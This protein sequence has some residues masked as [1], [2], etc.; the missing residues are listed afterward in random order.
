MVCGGCK[1][2]LFPLPTVIEIAPPRPDNALP[3]P[4]DTEPLLPLL[5]VPVDNTTNPLTP[6]VPALAV[7]INMEPEFVFT[8]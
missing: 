3:V 6:P 7:W 2:Y 4:I 8:L 5:D 1:A